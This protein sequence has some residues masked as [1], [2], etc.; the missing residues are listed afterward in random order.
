[1]GDVW[2]TAYDEGKRAMGEDPTGEPVRELEAGELGARDER[3]VGQGC[4]AV[5]RQVFYR[6]WEIWVGWVRFQ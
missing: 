1:M 4:C 5:L 3:F 2:V 6:D